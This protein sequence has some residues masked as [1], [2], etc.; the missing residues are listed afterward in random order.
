MD[1]C[2][3]SVP[4]PPFQEVGLTVHAICDCWGHLGNGLG[5]PDCPI[6]GERIREILG[7]YEYQEAMVQ[8]E[9]EGW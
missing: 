4:C 7:E 6:H 3:A 8:A 2:C 5:N 1:E 9:E